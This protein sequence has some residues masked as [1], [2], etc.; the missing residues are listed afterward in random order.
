MLGLR[1]LT[2]SLRGING[3]SDCALQTI[4][5]EKVI[6]IE[7]RQREFMI[8]QKDYPFKL[9]IDYN[10]PK[11]TTRLNHVF[12]GKGGFTV[13]QHHQES[14]IITKRYMTQK[15]M[16]EDIENIMLLKE[17]MKEYYKKANEEFL[18]NI[19]LKNSP[20]NKPKK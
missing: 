18:K 7:G 10:L 14:Q 5:V 2:Y 17:K 4:E 19:D 8:F 6:E 9:T 1:G 3:W 15:I 13:S 11:T 20:N 12:G 16:E